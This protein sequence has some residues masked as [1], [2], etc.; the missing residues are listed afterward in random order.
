[1]TENEIKKAK[2]K[3]KK[4][5]IKAQKEAEAKKGWLFFH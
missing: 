3:A 5:A 1:M 2:N 4:A